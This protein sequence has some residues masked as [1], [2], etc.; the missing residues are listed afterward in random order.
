MQ[1]NL[2][3]LN[4]KQK[5][6]FLFQNRHCIYKLYFLAYYKAVVSKWHKI[7]LNSNLQ[8]LQ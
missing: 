1:F 5:S 8:I 7:L 4:M 2:S 6:K 3:H